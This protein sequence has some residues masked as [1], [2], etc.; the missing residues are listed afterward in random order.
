MPRGYLPD[1]L[2]PSPAP[3]TSESLYPALKMALYSSFI[4][5][6]PLWKGSHGDWNLSPQLGVCLPPKWLGGDAVGTRLCLG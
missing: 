5:V 4:H 1:P 6:L 2:I 3:A